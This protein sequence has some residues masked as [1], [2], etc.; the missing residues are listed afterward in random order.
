MRQRRGTVVEPPYSKRKKESVHPRQKQRN[1]CNFHLLEEHN[2]YCSWKSIPKLVGKELP[3]TLKLPTCLKTPAMQR[4][5]THICYILSNLLSHKTSLLMRRPLRATAREAS[6]AALSIYCTSQSS[7]DLPGSSCRLISERTIF[8]N[9]LSAPCHTKTLENTSPGKF[10]Q[11]VRKSK[12]QISTKLSIVEFLKKVVG[13]A[14]S[15]KTYWIAGTYGA[16]MMK[17]NK[18]GIWG[19]L[20]I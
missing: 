6:S 9:N 14:H 3:Q 13:T 8:L 16:N 1:S 11:L 10:K 17:W 18:S 15:L 7:K 19:S 12:S 4:K 20:C 5:E 2:L